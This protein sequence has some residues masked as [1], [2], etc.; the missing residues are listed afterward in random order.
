[1]LKCHED[2]N[3]VGK[4]NWTFAFKVF[5][6]KLVFVLYGCEDIWGDPWVFRYFILSTTLHLFGKMLR[7]EYIDFIFYIYFILFF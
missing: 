4:T 7:D 2:T 5:R 1:M 3:H 6:I